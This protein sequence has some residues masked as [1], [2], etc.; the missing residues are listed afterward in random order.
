M[1]PPSLTPAQ[2]RRVAATP[3]GLAYA[4]AWAKQGWPVLPCRPRDE[5]DRKAKSPYPA[6]GKLAATRD[7]D[8]IRAWWAQWPSALVGGRTDG[9]V[10]LDFDAYGRGHEIDL[11]WLAGQGDL[12]ETREFTTPGKGGVRGRHLVYL[13]PDGL[14]RSRKLGPNKTIETRAGGSSDY[15]ILPPSRSAEGR[16]EVARWRTP[17]LVPGFLAQLAGRSSVN[18][19][20]L[21]SVPAPEPIRTL[22]KAEVLAIWRPYRTSDSEHSFHVAAVAFGCGRSE[23]E[24]VSVLERD[25]VTAARWNDPGRKGL[26]ER[27]L[28]T[29]LPRARAESEAYL[30]ARQIRAT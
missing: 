11:A 24:V 23:G 12:P 20:A 15:V 25:P 16:Y 21:S 1:E 3:P 7:P 28:R 9:L 10:V 13:D 17:A 26:R 5:G 30:A 6:R 2:C 27:E 4:L 14:C 22:A 29:M 18:A 19:E 8:Q